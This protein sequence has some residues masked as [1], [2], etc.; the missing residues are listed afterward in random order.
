LLT[1]CA[2]IRTT[3]AAESAHRSTAEPTTTASPNRSTRRCDAACAGD[4]AGAGYIPAVPR[5]FH[6]PRNCTSP[7]NIPTA[8]MAKPQCHEL[9][10]ENPIEPRIPLNWLLWANQ[11]HT[12]GAMKAPVLIP[13]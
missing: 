9:S 3:P 12:S 11:P 7:K 4:S 6:P 1:P 10:A 5:Y 2:V 13:M 8:A